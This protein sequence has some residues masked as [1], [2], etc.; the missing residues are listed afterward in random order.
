[1][2]EGDSKPETPRKIR[3]NNFRIVHIHKPRINFCS[4]LLILIMTKLIYNQNRG[5]IVPTRSRTT[6]APSSKTN[7]T[8]RNRRPTYNRSKSRFTTTTESYHESS[9]EPTKAKTPET[10]QKYNAIEQRRPASRTHKYRNRDR[11][12]SQSTV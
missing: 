4:Y 5:R 10:T 2:Y 1:M 8:E 11:T 3:R 9:Y 12:S 6:Q 7:N